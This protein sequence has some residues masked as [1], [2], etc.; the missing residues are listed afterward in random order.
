MTSAGRL[1]LLLFHSSNYLGVI[2]SVYVN[3]ANESGAGVVFSIKTGFFFSD[4]FVQC[5]EGYYPLRHDIL[6]YLYFSLFARHRFAL[7]EGV[8][9]QHVGAPVAF[10]RRRY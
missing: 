2:F 7:I 10:R 8:Q 4:F 5:R 3:H 1:Q 6:I 9:C